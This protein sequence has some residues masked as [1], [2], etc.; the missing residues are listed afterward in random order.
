MVSR[1]YFSVPFCVL[2]FYNRIVASCLLLIA[3]Y[4]ALAA[5]EFDIVLLSRTFDD[6]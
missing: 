3:A 6:L 4:V 5:I 1:F 2:V